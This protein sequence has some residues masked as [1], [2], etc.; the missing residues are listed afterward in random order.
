MRTF[1]DRVLGGHTEERAWPV[2]AKGEQEVARRLGKLGEGWQCLHAVPVGDNGS[3]IDHV[4]IG[5]GGVFTLNTKHHPGK[6]VW[7]GERALLVSGH[8]TDYLRDSRFEGRRASKLLSVACGVPVDAQPL[9]VVMASELKIKAQPDDI[10]VVG[11][12][13]IAKWLLRRPAEALRGQRG[14]STR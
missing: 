9:I 11:R 4:V 14:T 1:V 7:V 3:D 5:P 2:G 6:Q 10:K 13:N 8:R 12:R